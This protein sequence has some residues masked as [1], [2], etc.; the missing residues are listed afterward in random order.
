MGRQGQGEGEV[1]GLK[2]SVEWYHQL[3]RLMLTDTSRESRRGGSGGGGGGGS[4]GGGGGDAAA[5]EARNGRGVESQL[6]H[7]SEW[8]I[9][10]P[11][12]TNDTNDTNT[13]DPVSPYGIVLVR[14][15]LANCILRPPHPDPAHAHA[16][17]YAHSHAHGNGHDRPRLR[18]TAESSCKLLIDAGVPVL[19]ETGRV[20]ANGTVSAVGVGYASATPLLDFGVPEQC[21]GI[22]RFN[23][24]GVLRVMDALH[25]NGS[26]NGS[27]NGSDGRVRFDSSCWSPADRDVLLEWLSASI[28]ELR[29][30][31]WGAYCYYCHV[32]PLLP[33]TSCCS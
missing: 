10:F 2:L 5:A 18:G 9:A 17:A 6:A 13:V 14:S 16:H 8:P 31:G 25:H 32:F 12:Y 22:V 33:L 24:G 1:S 28:G 20:E 26:T 3:W 11:C 19:C 15:A 29:L 27:N 21:P 4:G 23:A 30:V 7:I